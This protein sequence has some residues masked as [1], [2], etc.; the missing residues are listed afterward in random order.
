MCVAYEPF[1]ALRPCWWD[2]ASPCSCW[3]A[4]RATLFA[5]DTTCPPP[6]HS[7][8]RVGQSSAAGS[9]ALPAA[10][11]HQLIV[12]RGSGEGSYGRHIS[13]PQDRKML[14]QMGKKPRTCSRSRTTCHMTRLDLLS[15]FKQKQLFH[16]TEMVGQTAT[17]CGG[18]QQVQKKGLGSFTEKCCKS[19]NKG[20]SA[21]EVSSLLLTGC[22]EGSA[23][24]GSLVHLSQAAS[25]RL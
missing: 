2:A 5:V 14:Q 15:D 20:L 23:W 9:R 16:T 1:T 8:L 25:T 24:A 12:H 10:I 13:M 22:W 17:G 3:L 7:R 18:S 6:Q 4:Q 21:Q 11:P 19:S